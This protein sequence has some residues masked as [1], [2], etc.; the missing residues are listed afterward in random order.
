M[1][2]AGGAA[3]TGPAGA[4]GRERDRLRARWTDTGLPRR[5]LACAATAIACVAA[6]TAASAAERKAV[7]EGVADRALASLLQRTVGDSREPPANRLSARRRAREAAETVETVLRAEGWY[8]A[9]ITPD[10]GTGARPQA[11]VRVKLGRRTTISST[12]VL[13][14]G[15]PPEPAARVGAEAAGFIDKGSPGRTAEV[16]ATEGRVIAQLQSLGYAD[17]KADPRQVYVDHADASMRPVFHIDSGAIVKMDGLKLDGVGRTN[18]AWIESLR[19]WAHGDL[20]RPDDVAEL[21]RRLQDTQ[22]YDTVAV[23]LAAADDADGLRPVVV[24]LTDRP[25]RA[26]DLSAGYSTTEGADFDLRFTRYNLLHR[27]D[28]LTL[29]ARLA[30]IDS[31]YGGELS[32]PHWREP[33]QTLRTSLYYLDTDTDAYIERGEQASADVTRRY[34]KTSYLTVGAVV[35]NTRVDDRHTPSIDI[36]GFRAFVAFLLDRTDAPL[37]A[38]SGYRLDARLTPTDIIGDVSDR[39]LKAVIQGAAFHSLDRAG[40]TVL[41]VRV[42]LGSILGSSPNGV[43]IS[44]R[45][46]AGGGGSVRGYEYQSIGPTFADTSPIG[47]LSLLEGSFEVRRRIGA[48]PFGVVGFVDAGAVGRTLRPDISDLSPAIG[49]GVRYALPFAPVRLDIA[50]PLRDPPGRNLPPIQVYISVGQSF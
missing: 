4:P 41:A 8:D 15:T 32:L 46:F 13:F 31:R 12:Q 2:R 37:D 9:E 42:R 3:K 26:F 18:P 50:T 11:V 7:I 19:P 40:Q 20:Y 14:D 23:A 45:F 1:T 34:G 17:A 27:A 44:D 22:V 10:V 28:T 33:G 30:E 43:P 25:R 38:R 36:Q 24:A 29:Q 47:G 16:L 21:E 5:R 39:Y 48:T 6:A 35:S 49:V